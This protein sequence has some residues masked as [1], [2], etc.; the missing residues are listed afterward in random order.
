M[1]NAWILIDYLTYLLFLTFLYLCSLRSALQSSRILHKHKLSERATMVVRWQ[2]THSV[3]VDNSCATTTAESF[4]SLS[5]QPMSLSALCG[6]LSRG[7]VLLLRVTPERI[8]TPIPALFSFIFWSENRL[9]WWFSW[10]SCWAVA[11]STRR[12]A[13]SQLLVWL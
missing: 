13:S 11:S 8:F 2:W 9:R 10:L 1:G 3:H 4:S 6:L 7:F 5:Q 12:L